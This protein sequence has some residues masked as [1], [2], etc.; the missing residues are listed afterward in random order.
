MVRWPDHR[1]C[2]SGLSVRFSGHR[3]SLCRVRPS[4][5]ARRRLR[6][7]ARCK[8]RRRPATRYVHPCLHRSS[9]ACLL[10][11]P[12]DPRIS[13]LVS[14]F[15]PLATYY[16]AITAFIEQYSVLEHGTVNHALCAAIR[17]MLKVSPSLSF[18]CSELM[19]SLS[20]TISYSSPGSKSSSTRRLPSPFSAFGCSSTPPST[21]LRSSTP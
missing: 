17:E 18:E 4:I 10:P 14:R 8:V 11:S 1:Y 13:A 6:T 5:H 21:L 16:T 2:Q 20:R 7:A 9:S 3:G 12:A 15:L 19:S